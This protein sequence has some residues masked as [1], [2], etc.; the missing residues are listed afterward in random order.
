MIT[1]ASAARIVC[2]LRSTLATPSISVIE[3]ARICAQAFGV[4]LT[5]IVRTAKSSQCAPGWDRRQTI[6]RL[7]G[8]FIANRVFRIVRFPF[9]NIAILRGILLFHTRD[10]RIEQPQ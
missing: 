7:G 5:E 3:P 2:P 10:P 9:Q 1:V 6:S 8:L 4:R